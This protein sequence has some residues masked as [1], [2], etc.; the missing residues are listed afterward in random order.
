MYV[1]HNMNLTDTVVTVKC[2]EPQAV[3]SNIMGQ[4]SDVL[5]ISNVSS[6]IENKLSIGKM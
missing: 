1:V 3:T 4:G 6:K 2:I 5:S